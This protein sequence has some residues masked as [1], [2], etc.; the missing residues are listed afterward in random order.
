MPRTWQGSERTVVPP[1]ERDNCTP[2]GRSRLRRLVVTL[3]GAQSARRLV[4]APT[5][6]TPNLVSLPPP[7]ETTDATLLDHWGREWNV[8]PWRRLTLDD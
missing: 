5:S 2:E 6:R 8:Q 3:P 7:K 1:D 4:A